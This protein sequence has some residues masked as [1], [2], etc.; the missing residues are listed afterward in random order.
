MTTVWNKIWRRES[1]AEIKFF[2]ELISAE[3]IGGSN[4]YNENWSR[5]LQTEKVTNFLSQQIMAWGLDE[6]KSSRIG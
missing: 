6:G 5:V 2:L 3:H 1:E 4:L